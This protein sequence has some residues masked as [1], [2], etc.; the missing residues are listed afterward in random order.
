M[1]PIPLVTGWNL[2]PFVDFLHG[3]G[4]PVERWLADCRIPAA[5]LEQPG[6]TVPLV[7]ALDFAEHVARAEGAD[8]LGLD[9]GRH[10]AAESLGPFGSMLARCPTLY[11]RAQTSCRLLSRVNNYSSMWLEADGPEVRL[12]TRY[13]CDRV[14]ALRHAEDF[15]LMLMLEAIGR[16]AGPGWKPAAIRLPGTRSQRFERDELFQGVRMSYGEPD[17]SIAFSADLLARPLRKLQGCELPRFQAETPSAGDAVA[18]EF[19]GS[20]Q[21][22]I[23]ALLPLGC[24]SAQELADIANTTS[25]TLQR[26]LAESGTSLRQVTDWARFHLADEYLRG[27]LASITDIAFELG[28]SDSTAFTRSFHRLTGVAPSSYRARSLDG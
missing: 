13:W 15:T 16:A 4:A 11:D 14:A 6:R 21:D 18:A 22:T 10:A 7:L 24:P 1:R 17:I 27:T 5:I 9:V 12:H 28:Y 19:I 25:R 20:L 26:R 3:I 8:S 2:L 23:V